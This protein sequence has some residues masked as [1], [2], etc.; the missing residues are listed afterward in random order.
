MFEVIN[1]ASTFTADSLSMTLSFTS[2]VVVHVEK[3]FILRKLLLKCRVVTMST[4]CG[5]G[6]M[7]FRNAKAHKRSLPF[8]I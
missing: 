4:E 7:G 5:G 8:N 1:S 2:L 6:F 3:L